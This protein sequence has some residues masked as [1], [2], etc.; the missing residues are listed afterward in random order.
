MRKQFLHT[1]ATMIVAGTLCLAAPPAM[2]DTT[3]TM[4]PGWNLV[5]SS[6]PVSNAASMFGDPQK[7][8]SVWAWAPSGSGGAGN[9]KVLMA[10]DTTNSY[11]QAM[12]FGTLSA[13]KADEGFW[14]NSAV[15]QTVTIPGMA[16][17]DTTIPLVDGWNL[18]GVNSVCNAQTMFNAMVPGTKTYMY[19]S[20]WKWDGNAWSVFMPGMNSNGMMGGGNSS[21]YGQLNT[22]AP[23]QGYWVNV[24]P[25][26]GVNALNTGGN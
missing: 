11:A 7:F 6:T 25:G 21:G 17:T 4:H 13:I 15:Q 10:N 24:P 16:S 3:I 8:I 22:L 5:S 19:T 1:G 20:V 12:G 18:I 9:W 14:V 26:V 2:A 23:G